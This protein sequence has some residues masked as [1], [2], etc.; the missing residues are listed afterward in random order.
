MLKNVNNQR[1]DGALND[2]SELDTII[3]TRLHDTPWQIHCCVETR[4]MNHD[5]CDEPQPM[6]GVVLISMRL[7]QVNE[8]AELGRDGIH[9]L[10][11]N[12]GM[13]TVCMIH[14]LLSA[15]VCVNIWCLGMRARMSCAP[16]A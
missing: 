8:I 16:S 6:K 4:F 11:S 7:L 12:V 10:S 5:V 1:N 3:I 14:R 9:P 15:V 13:Q 2:P